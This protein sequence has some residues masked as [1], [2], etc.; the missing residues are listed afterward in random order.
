MRVT[1]FY[2]VEEVGVW[3]KWGPWDKGDRGGGRERE[4]KLQVTRLHGMGK[5][6][7]VAG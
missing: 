7:E 4:N 2:D 1:P 3:N 6:F 5:A